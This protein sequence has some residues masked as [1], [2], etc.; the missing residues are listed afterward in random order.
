MYWKI[1][2]LSFNEYLFSVDHFKNI[3]NLNYFWNNF[4]VHF[5]STIVSAS[6]CKCTHV[7]DKHAHFSR[8]KQESSGTANVVFAGIS[9]RFTQS[10]LYNW[11]SSCCL[12]WIVFLLFLK[13]LIEFCEKGK[14]FY[15]L[16][17]HVLEYRLYWYIRQ[18][19]F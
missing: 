17:S 16:I 18:T 5:V 11:Y 9:L 10:K 14:E 2:R 4:A 8:E 6:L 3:N 7:Q 1:L 12:K 13:K 15:L 19:D